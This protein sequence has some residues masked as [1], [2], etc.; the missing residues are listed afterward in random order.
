MKT[1]FA[2]AA[3]VALLTATGCS[4]TDTA[5]S[6]AAMVQ[7]WASDRSDFETIRQ[8]VTMPP[9]ILRIERDE[10]GG[11]SVLP[12]DASRERVAT[13]GSLMQRLGVDSVST[14]LSLQPS[15]DFLVF[16]Q[17]GRDRYESRMFTHRP[18][19]PPTE[20]VASIDSVIRSDPDADHTVF[21]SL[22]ESWYIRASSIP[23]ASRQ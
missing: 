1:I 3:G 9:R 5:P 19:D 13:I 11:L 17:A 12:V 4:Q 20:T 14:D 8:A 22:G 2:A 6:E 21:M 23:A 16:E 10:D 15:V 7:Q 18:S